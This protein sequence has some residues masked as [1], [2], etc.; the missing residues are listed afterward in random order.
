MHKIVVTLLV[1]IFGTSC[2]KPPKTTENLWPSEIERY[3][4]GPQFL[5]IP[6]MDWKLDSGRLVCLNPGGSKGVVLLTK[7]I[8]HPMEGFEITFEGGFVGKTYN[9]ADRM[10]MMLGLNSPKG[11]S[12]DFQ[13]GVFAGVTADGMLLLMGKTSKMKSALTTDE[14]LI[15]SIEGVPMENGKLQLLLRVRN[16][17]GDNQLGEVKVESNGEQ[18]KGV[19]SFYVRAN[20]KASPGAMAWFESL[21]ITGEGVVTTPENARGPIL[22]IKDSIRNGV[23]NMKAFLAP[24]LRDSGNRVVLQIR[25]GGEWTTLAKEPVPDDYVVTFPPRKLDASVSAYRVYTRYIDRYG[26]QKYSYVKGSFGRSN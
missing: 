6:A 1:I 7:S 5:S 15:F 17:A 12:V 11:N 19:V 2:I 14:K 24:L 13:K 22:S 9:R 3:W 4:V 21:E 16:E 23:L 18:I 20:E 25:D 10:G 26:S 8:E